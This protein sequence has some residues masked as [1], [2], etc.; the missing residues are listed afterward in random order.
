ME[1][2]RTASKGTRRPIGK[3][4]ASMSTRTACSCWIRSR[5][6]AGVHD[7]HP[8]I[9][10]LSMSQPFIFPDDSAIVLSGDPLPP[11]FVSGVF[12]AQKKVFLCN[13]ARTGPA[14]WKYT[15]RVIHKENLGAIDL[16][17]SLG[18][19][20]LTSTFTWWSAMP[21]QAARRLDVA[22]AV[23]GLRVIDSFASDGGQWPSEDESVEARQKSFRLSHGVFEG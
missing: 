1:L 17:R 21:A 3:T 7:T 23:Q 18:P 11:D 9:W 15:V 8:L 6:V 19:P 12:G 16:A 22:S 14:V 2:I 5:F 20:E 13:Y 4:A 10:R